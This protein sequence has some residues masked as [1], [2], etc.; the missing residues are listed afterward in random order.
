MPSAKILIVDDEEQN[1]ELIEIILSREGYSL[2]FA[3]NGEEALVILEKQ[4]IDILLLD[5][6]MPKMDGLTT[7]K[8]MKKNH[9]KQPYIIVISALGDKINRTKV[10][11]LGANNYILKPFDI[12]DL[13]E[14]IRI[15]LKEETPSSSTHKITL[16][17]KECRK[18]SITFL[19][20]EHNN[21]IEDLNYLIKLLKQIEAGEYN[22]VEIQA[23]KKKYIQT[24]PLPYYI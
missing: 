18:L 1:R 11:E 9:Q 3:E 22:E 21:T 23:L 4:S 7:L 24:D 20:K 10:R 17:E 8:K 6:L 16:S 13:K 2:L 12:I 19:Q 15:A 5:L 14:R